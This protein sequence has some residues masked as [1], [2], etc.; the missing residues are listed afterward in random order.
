MSPTRKNRVL[1]VIPSRFGALRLPGKPL[2]DETGKPMVQHV[3]EQVCR[4]RRVDRIVIAT[5]DERIR[6]AA[7]AFGAEALMTS[8]SHPNGTSRCAEAA[9]KLPCDW[10]IN[11]QGDE[12][13]LDPE[14]IDRTVDLLKGAEMSTAATPH[15]PESEA[16][17]PNRVKVVTDKEGWALYFSRSRIPSA[18]PCLL[19]VG[20]YGFRK[21]FLKKVARFVP[22]PLQ[23]LERLE[24]LRVLENG[25]RIRVAVVEKPNPGGIDTPEDYARFVARYRESKSGRKNC[26]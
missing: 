12:P 16:S 22:T 8:A 13:D 20:V 10:V 6:R 3:W 25:H 24:Q 5:D 14:F 17:N 4:A 18:G 15:L 23:E 2:L 1:V 9:A 11:V 21:A 19:H 26:P 7:Q